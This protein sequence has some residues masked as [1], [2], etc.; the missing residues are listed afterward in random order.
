VLVN[1][2][3][4]EANLKHGRRTKEKLSAQRHAVEVGRPKLDGA[5]PIF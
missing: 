2:R 1:S 4:S 5:K 3:I